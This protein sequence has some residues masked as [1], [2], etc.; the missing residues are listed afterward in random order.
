MKLM[1]KTSYALAL[2]CFLVASALT[3]A[4]AFA[5]AKGKVL[6]V[7]SNVLDMGDPEVVGKLFGKILAIGIGEK[8]SIPLEEKY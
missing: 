3:P 1:A 2:T 4:A 6:F 5:A 8:M 7:A